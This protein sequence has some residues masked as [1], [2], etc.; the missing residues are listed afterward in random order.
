[1]PVLR[2]GLTADGKPTRQDGAF[3]GTEMV[4]GQDRQGAEHLAA[5]GSRLVS[6][7]MG[8]A[9]NPKRVIADGYDRM[10]VRFDAWN[11][12]RSPEVRSWFLGQVLTRLRPGSTVLELGCGPGTDAA[13]LSAGRRY[14]GVDLSEVQ[15]RIARRRVPDATLVVGDITSIAFR[16]AS[17]DGVVGFYVF[18]HVPQVEV[19][20]TFA[21][22]FEWLRPGGW[23][24]TSLLSAEAEDRVEEWLNVQMFFAGVRPHSY[25]RSLR[26]TG[27][28]I[29]LSEFRE[30]ID[31]RYGPGGHPWVIARKP[32]DADD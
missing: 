16:P 29:E 10:G 28:K 20:P 21:R 26:R 22:I 2:E 27:F 12:S 23:L 11:A 7:L 18:N 3:L 17:F 30:E 31:P 19:D 14:V 6:W 4:F 8:A 15:L 13:Q 9:M 5:P 24:M 32:D 25:E 1:L